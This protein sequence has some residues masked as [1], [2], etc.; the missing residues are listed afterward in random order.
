MQQRR[1]WLEILHLEGSEPTCPKT[2][3]IGKTEGKKN[4][5]CLETS[6]ANWYQR[7]ENRIKLF[8]LSRVLNIVIKHADIAVCGRILCFHFS[9]LF[10]SNWVLIPG[11]QHSLY[12]CEKTQCKAFNTKGQQIT[13]KSFKQMCQHCKSL[14]DNKPEISF[15]VFLK[16]VHLR[17]SQKSLQ[18]YLLSLINWRTIYS[19]YYRFLS[20]K[21]PR[22]YTFLLCSYYTQFWYISFY[23]CAHFYKCV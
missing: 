4:N 1:K 18:G 5:L 19:W 7:I 11:K 16:V 12:S 3:L 9:C 17:F 14:L 6:F 21:F 10:L 15:R 2:G 20:K 13:L 22:N 23:V 8:F